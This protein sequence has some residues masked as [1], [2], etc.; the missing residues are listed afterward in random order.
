MF[1]D[2]QLGKPYMTRGGKMAIFQAMDNDIATLFLEDCSFSVNK[3]GYFED[4]DHPSGF[5]IIE[6]FIKPLSIEEL[7]DLAWEYLNTI[8]IPC[9][10]EETARE[11]Y[12]AGAQMMFDKLVAN[13]ATNKH[14]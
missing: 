10:Y 2:A 9:R 11:A 6:E 13:H 12:K 3:D 8:F 14:I 4:E 1:E 5:D 7:D